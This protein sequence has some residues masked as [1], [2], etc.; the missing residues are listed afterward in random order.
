MK[1]SLRGSFGIAQISL[2]IVLLL[3]AVA[4]PVAT[5]L[6][7]DEQDTRDMAKTTEDSCVGVV[8]KTNY[9]C[10]AGGCVYTRI[11]TVKPTKKAY[12]GATNNTLTCELWGGYFTSFFKKC[13]GS[14]DFAIKNYSNHKFGQKCCIPYSGNPLIQDR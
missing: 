2:L 12:G 9:K 3:M 8:C 1:N 14:D 13:L 10:V 7:Q 6:V 11:P 5:K 4:V